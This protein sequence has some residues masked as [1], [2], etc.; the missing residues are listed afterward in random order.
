MLIALLLLLVYL[1]GECLRSL[2]ETLS[3]L[4]RSND[5]CVYF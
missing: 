3:A 5:D 4:P 2:R 1:G